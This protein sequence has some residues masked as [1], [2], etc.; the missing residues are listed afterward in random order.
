MS[1]STTALSGLEQ[2]RSKIEGVAR[3]LATLPLSVSPWDGSDSVDLSA[4]AVSLLQA[5][6]AYEVSLKAAKA[7]NELNKHTLDLLA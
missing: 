5:Q 6:T 4:E 3:S 1:T 7:A 2:A